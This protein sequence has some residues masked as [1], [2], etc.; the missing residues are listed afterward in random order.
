[1]KKA[2]AKWAPAYKKY[3]M[4]LAELASLGLHSWLTKTLGECWQ[5][6]H[7]RADAGRQQRP[8]QSEV[9]GHGGTR[10]LDMKKAG[11]VGA[12]L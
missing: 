11:A 2:G 10:V 12:S 5:R 7:E 4:N 9:E 3:R 8:Q 6:L 1:M